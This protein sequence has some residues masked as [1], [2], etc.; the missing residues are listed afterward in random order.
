MV[1]LP[2]LWDGRYDEYDLLDGNR[3]RFWNW[4]KATP[5]SILT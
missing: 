1:E 2:L 5:G 4:P 3:D